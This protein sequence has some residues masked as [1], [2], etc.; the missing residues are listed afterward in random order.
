MLLWPVA[1]AATV[2]ALAACDPTTPDAAPAAPGSAAGTAVAAPPTAG[3]A[4]PGSAQ[5]TAKAGGGGGGG[6]PAAAPAGGDCTKPPLA[7]GHKVVYLSKPTTA[8]AISASDTT[9]QCE[10]DTDF[11]AA[12]APKTYAFAAGA[13]AELNHEGSRKA[14]TL[15]QLATH[16]GKCLSHQT[17]PAAPCGGPVYD[18]ALD[19]S[20]RISQITEV[21]F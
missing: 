16:T 21:W 15:A 1:T 5:P 10:P 8:T 14:V 3:G 19:S 7:A 2:V 11:V 20:G 9:W 17:D 4:V 13:K 6:T 18:I 12:G